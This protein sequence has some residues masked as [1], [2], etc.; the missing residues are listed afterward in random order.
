MK[1]IAKTLSSFAM[2]GILSACAGGTLPSGAPEQTWLSPSERAFLNIQRPYPNFDDVCVLLGKSETTAAMR[3]EGHELIA[4]PKHE[5]GATDD[6]RRSGAKIV[7]QSEYWVIL[8]IASD[9][10]QAQLQ[11]Y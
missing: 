3:T 9:L 2:M 1:S 7:G 11:R 10:A 4:C 5:T 6:R 8:S